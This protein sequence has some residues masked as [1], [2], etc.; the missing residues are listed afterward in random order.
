M[1]CVGDS[2]NKN[3]VMN[4]LI[5]LLINGSLYYTK[6][7]EQRRAHQLVFY[8]FPTKISAFN[9]FFHAFLAKNSKFI[10]Q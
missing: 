4:H 10:W 6:N 5:W 2:L 1:I 3:L 7:P 8:I 9:A